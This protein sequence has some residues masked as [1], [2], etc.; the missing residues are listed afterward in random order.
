MDEKIK[1]LN[2]DMAALS[3]AVD[4]AVSE[5]KRYK[6]LE[7]LLESFADTIDGP[8]GPMPN[9]AMAILAEWRNGI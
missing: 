6:R 3:V 7:E 2:D 5:I 8:D 4:K 1:S 9:Q